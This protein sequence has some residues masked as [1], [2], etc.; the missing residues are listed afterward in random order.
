MFEFGIYALILLL[1]ALA[2]VVVPLM[3]AKTVVRESDDSANI[4]LAKNKLKEL[5]AELAGGN[6]TQADYAV[7]KQ[8]L[9]IGLYHD[10]QAAQLQQSGSNGRWI[11]VPLLFAIPVISLGLYAQLGDF[12]AFDPP[13]AMMPADQQEATRDQLETMVA[14]LEQRMHE[15]PTVEGWV[16]LGRSYKAMKRFD[17]AIVALKKAQ[18]LQPDNPDIM[19]QIADA[20]AVANDGSLQGEP[21]NMIDKA[22]KLQPD[23]EIGLWL[24][25]MSRAELG[26]YDAA[27]ATWRKLQQR[28]QAGQPEYQEVQQMID[29]ALERSGKAPEAPKPAPAAAS[30][31][32]VKVQVT[33]AAAMKTAISP[34]DSVLVYVKAANGP[35]MPLAAVKRQAKDLP[36]SVT[37]DDSM[38]MMPTLK[39][40]S[41]DEVVVTARISKSGNAIPQSG[42]PIGTTKVSG[43]QRNEV[44]IVIDQRVP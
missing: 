13:A 3:L 7:A 40:S 35:K 1:M 43:A 12:R 11:S 14:K 26:Q 31:P 17:D 34:E 2:F 38:A 30:T 6:L 36:L 28:Y 32:T 5:K 8:E 10:L 20:L 42:E 9:E 19:L 4:Q 37:F 23:N 39:I 29:T 27:I 22:L 18:D 21:S 25:G 16:M 44:K 41:V 15:K 24:S 33:L